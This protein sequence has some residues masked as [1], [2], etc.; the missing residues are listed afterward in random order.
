MFLTLGRL[1]LACIERQS[2]VMWSLIQTNTTKFAVKIKRVY[3]VVSSLF[4]HKV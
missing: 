4:I 1:N 2:K 3:T